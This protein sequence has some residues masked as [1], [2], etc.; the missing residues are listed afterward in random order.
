MTSTV[1]ITK[2]DLR[3]VPLGSRYGETRRAMEQL[4]DGGELELV[5]DQDPRSIQT[6]YRLDFPEEPQWIYLACGPSIWRATI[7]KSVSSGVGKRSTC[8]GAC[9]GG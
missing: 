8:C 2:L 9:G 6:T 5:S 1:S 3:G 4:P 7:F